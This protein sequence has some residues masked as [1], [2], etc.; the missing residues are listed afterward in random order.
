[1][2]THTFFERVICEG[3][4]CESI[5]KTSFSLENTFY[6]CTAILNLGHSKYS[7]LRDFIRKLVAILRGEGGNMRGEICKSLQYCVREH[8]TIPSTAKIKDFAE[9]LGT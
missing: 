9:K 8:Y 6:L 2:C 1:M 7:P 4:I 5:L 3:V